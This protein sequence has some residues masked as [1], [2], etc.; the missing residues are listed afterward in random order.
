[1]ASG[2]AAETLPSVLSDPEALYEIVNGEYVEAPRMGVYSS[3]LATALCGYLWAHSRKSQCGFPAIETLFRL[4]PEGPSRRP[5]VAFVAFDRFRQIPEPSDQL[6]EWEA[7]PNLA[8][9]RG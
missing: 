1:M 8:V 7:V 9:E 5:D 6:G 2:T 4:T 3:L